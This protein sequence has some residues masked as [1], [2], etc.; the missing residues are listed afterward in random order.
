MKHTH[1]PKKLFVILAIII[2][3]ITLL[4]CKKNP[5]GVVP[6]SGVVKLDGNPLEGATVTFTPQDP[7]GHIASAISGPNGEFKLNTPSS[8]IPGAVPGSYVITVVRMDPV[9]ARNEE[10]TE[11]EKLGSGTRS[12][13]SY[14]PP[15]AVNHVTPVKYRTHT[16]SDLKA[17]IKKG[18]KNDITVD[19]QNE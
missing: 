6:A 17:T 1:L 12:S 11:E 5:L 18:S 16:T 3:A 4:G 14:D 15:P 7:N 9:N 10:A 13:S 2:P 19:M 8:P